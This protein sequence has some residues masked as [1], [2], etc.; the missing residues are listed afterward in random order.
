VLDRCPRPG[1]GESVDGVSEVRTKLDSVRGWAESRDLDGVL[2][3]SQAGFAWITCG[4]H[5]HISIGDPA[6]VAS[7]LVTVERAYLLTSN[8][9]LRRIFDEEVVALPFEGVEWP[10]HEQARLDAI[11]ADLCHP[12]RSV[13][14][15]GQS[16]LAQA[17]SSLTALRF[18]LLPP[19]VERFRALG[20]DAAESVEIACLSARPGDSELDVAARVAEECARR[21]ILALV[22]LVATDE[23]IAAYRHP[24]PTE[25][26]IE[27]TMLVALTG[28]RHGLHA[29]LT[30]M[31]TFGEPEDE[32]VARHH[33]VLRV[34]ARFLLES[35]PAATL[36]DVMAAAM[37]QYVAEGFGDEW[38]RHHQGGLTGYAGREVFATPGERHR[39]EPGQALAWNPSITR[40][41]S[42]D[43]VIVGEEGVEVL[44][45]T[46]GWPRV[47]VELQ[48][49]RVTRP[50]LLRR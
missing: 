29:S 22:N 39:L 40:V 10:W 18:T 8:I 3:G 7:I 43:T 46:H 47:E 30:R 35:R 42:E 27:R 25:R 1:R 38:R 48:G 2:I 44:T 37:E 50:T 9:E 6:G 16:G 21:N 49:L 34:D 4:G 45:S 26:R 41:K 14:D 5:N 33:A 17:D 36:G 19:E 31:V 32:L 24:L 11:V 15:L 28:R 23:R 20:R 13:S 12:A